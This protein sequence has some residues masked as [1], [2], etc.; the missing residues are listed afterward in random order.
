MES[1]T[2]GNVSDGSNAGKLGYW[3][4]LKIV[5][6]PIGSVIGVLGLVFYFAATSWV[7]NIARAEIAAAV[8]AAELNENTLIAHTGKLEQHDE[9]I[10]ENEEDIDEVDD[11]FTDFIR[12]V[13]AKL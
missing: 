10:K 6:L 9:E 12:D 8:T 5:A 1:G 2:N 13:I 3:D 4:A 11:K 7:Q